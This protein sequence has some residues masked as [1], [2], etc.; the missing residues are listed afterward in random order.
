MRFEGGSILGGGWGTGESPI[1]RGAS[2]GLYEFV[3]SC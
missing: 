3:A 1:G 2:Y